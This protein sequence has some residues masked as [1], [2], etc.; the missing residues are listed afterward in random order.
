MSLNNYTANLLASG[1]SN[2]L[3]NVMP[4]GAKRISIYNNGPNPIH[5]GGSNTTITTST[6]FKIPAGGSFSFSP[7][8]INPP[9]I[10]IAET[11][12]QVSPANT[13]VM[14]EVAD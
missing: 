4:P 1:A 8:I 12:D 3:P 7:G 6:G 11:A 2:V 13:R 9:L 5:V 14:I 10:G